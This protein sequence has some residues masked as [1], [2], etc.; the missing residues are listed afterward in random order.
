MVFL[1]LPLL[2]V[3]WITA[4]THDLAARRETAA[5]LAAQAGMQPVRFDAGRFV[6]AGEIRMAGPR[7]SILR[8]YLEGDGFGYISPTQLSPNPTPY[9]PVGLRLAAAD[10]FPAVLYLARPCQ[11]VTPPEAR[12]CAPQ[13]WS[14]HRFA[15]E[16]IDATNQAI[17]QALAWTGTDRVVLI[18]YSGGGAVAA[19][20]AARRSDVVAWATVAAP[21]DH[22]A[23]TRWHAV[24]PLDGSLNPVDDA[25]R[26]A[27]LPQIHF[28]GTKDEVVPSEIL[29]GFLKHEG[30]GAE[31][32][33]VVIPGFD[34]VCCW[35]ARWPDLLR[36]WS[37]GPS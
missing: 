9:N 2:L 18:G 36:T 29:R 22:D 14:T 21:L 3:L 37:P 32:R 25:Q 23:W 12:S 33:L 16:V 35:V 17:T 11:Y 8:V 5:V 19:L 20:A 24:A 30:A 31:T 4:C 15:P 6:L 13:Y 1:R 27:G 7:Q 28:V 10:P 34:H 26:L